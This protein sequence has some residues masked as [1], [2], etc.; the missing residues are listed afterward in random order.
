[1][2]YSEFSNG[3]KI[4]D[5][6]RGGIGSLN[7]IL[8][9][10]GASR[11]MIIG[12]KFLLSEGYLDM[13]KERVLD[14]DKLSVGAVYICEDIQDSAGALRDMYFV[15]M[16]NNCDGIVVCGSGKLIDY[17]K[18]MR[19]SVSAQVKDVKKF[20]NN[21]DIGRKVIDVPLVTVPCRFGLGN[22]CNAMAVFY[23]SDKKLSRNIFHELLSPDYCIIDGE[24]LAGN[25]SDNEVVYGILNTLGRAIDGLIA[26]KRARVGINIKKV[27][28][29]NVGEVF[30]RVV[31]TDLRDKSLDLFESRDEKK[32]ARYALDSAYLAKGLDCNGM[33]MIYSTALAISDVKKIGYSQS[34][35]I[36]IRTSLDYNLR[37][38]GEK[39]SQALWA[40]VGWEEY[41]QYPSGAR[42]KAFVDCVKSFADNLLNKYGDGENQI[43][44]NDDDRQEIV[45]KMAYNPHMLN[46]PRYF[47]PLAIKAVMR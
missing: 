28:I 11:I 21:S 9:G 22:E 20:F 42:S 6:D 27:D 5:K 39:Y 13:I 46:N 45:N 17:V 7:K 8:R 1:M 44:L 30:S 16:S 18:I 19:L 33:G 25:M 38:C 12:D 15:Y 31:M 35:P 32:F 47:D 37:Y 4:I 29:H 10:L 14:G 3:T 23:D 40:F 26:I 24:I 2:R 41:S 34:L 36:A 43:K